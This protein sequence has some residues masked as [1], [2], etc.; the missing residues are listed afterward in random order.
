VREGVGDN[1][2]LSR[3]VSD[4]GHELDDKVEVV[5]LTQGTFIPLLLESV[6][7]GLVVGEDGKVAC[8]QHTT[9]ML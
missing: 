1:V 3:N 7:D 9:E 5:E 8:F 2:V 4:V 6:G